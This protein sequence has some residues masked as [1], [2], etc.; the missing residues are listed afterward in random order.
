MT[1]VRKSPRTM[2]DSEISKMLAVLIF[3]CQ[4]GVLN[5]NYANWPGFGMIVERMRDLG[6]ALEVSSFCGVADGAISFNKDNCYEWVHGDNLPRAAIE[7]ALLAVQQ[8]SR[9][10]VHKEE[11]E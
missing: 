10:S 2:S 11:N 3:N 4:E 1:Q 9:E 6:F 5:I 7:A 8:P